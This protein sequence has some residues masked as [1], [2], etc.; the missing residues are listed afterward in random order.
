ML[1]RQPVKPFPVAPQFVRAKAQTR[2]RIFTA[3]HHLVGNALQ[4]VAR[5]HC[6]TTFANPAPQQRVPPCLA[7][8][9]Q[10]RKM[11][12]ALGIGQ[13]RQLLAEQLIQQLLLLTA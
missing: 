1:S 12:C 8:G 13:L 11:Q 9:Q 2:L 3:V 7:T 6:T 4:R 10:R 5:G